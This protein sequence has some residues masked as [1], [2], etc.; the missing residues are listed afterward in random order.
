MADGCGVGHFRVRIL[1]EE[2]LRAALH[3]SCER[4]ATAALQRLLLL[5]GAQQ[6]SSCCKADLCRVSP[7]RSEI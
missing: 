4:E 5:T 2:S 3:Q 6:K 7:C 1:C